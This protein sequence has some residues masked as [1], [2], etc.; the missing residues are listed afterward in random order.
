MFDV[1]EDKVDVVLQK[2]DIVKVF[3]TKGYT[4]TFTPNEFRFVFTG[5]TRI[6]RIIDRLVACDWKKV[7][8]KNASL[9]STLQ[10]FRKKH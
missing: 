3:S 8:S 4:A 5:K 1:E 7:N 10:Y 6:K 9:Q 2:G